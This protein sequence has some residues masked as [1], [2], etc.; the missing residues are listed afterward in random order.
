MKINNSYPYPVLFMNNE[1][2]NNS[3][4]NA[5]IHIKE[6]F[7]EVEL[8]VVFHLDNQKI[9]QLIDSGEC[10]FSVHIE[11]GQTSFREV[12][13]TQNESI[14][15]AI[16]AD[17]LRGKILIHS[18]ILAN[19]QIENYT[20]QKLSEWYQGL[21]I[22]FEKGNLLA[23][24]NAIETTLYEDNE[25][26]LNLPSIISVTSSVKNEYM[27]VDMTQ[28]LIVVSLPE[29]E[30]NQYTHNR[31]TIF[32]D[33]ILANVFV[34]ALVQVFSNLNKEYDFED[35]TWYQVLEKIFAENNI[36]IED[37]GTDS[38]PALQAAQMVLKKP[39]RRS[40]EEIE[41]DAK[42]REER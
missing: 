13:K 26:M 4:F 34:P 21:P 20:N 36:N 12:F 29:Y 30:Y 8:Q 35:S 24:G 39:I 2:Y 40:F 6:S 7:G 1:D 28:D 10:V 16:P 33:T 23:I 38:L 18:F 11:C 37:V 27:E 15:I 22:S 5:D 42:R 17:K 32:K 41:Q 9:K 31:K 19:K 25:E 3:A 14:T